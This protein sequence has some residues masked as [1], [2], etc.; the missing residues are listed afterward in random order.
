MKITTMMTT[1]SMMMRLRTTA[2]MTMTMAMTARI[3]VGA[4]IAI[5]PLPQQRLSL[6][7]LR[8][9]ELQRSASLQQQGPAMHRATH[10]DLDG[11]CLEVAVV[12]WAMVVP[13]H[14]NQKGWKRT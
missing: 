8:Q 5:E 2:T 13:E 3:G 4:D 12:H 11:E 7:P 6:S 10:V 9:F 14:V 1:T